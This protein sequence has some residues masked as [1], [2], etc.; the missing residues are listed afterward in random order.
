MTGDA[1]DGERA[2]GMRQASH[3]SCTSTR[4]AAQERGHGRNFAWLRSHLGAF[5]VVALCGVFFAMA[6]GPWREVAH[7]FF[8]R[9]NPFWVREDFTAFY[10]AGHIVGSGLGSHLYDPGT[11]RAAEYAAAGRQ[12]GGTGLLMYFNPPFFALLYWPLSHL[13]LQQAYQAW[14]LFSVGLLALNSWLLVRLTPGLSRRWHVVLITGYLT[15]YPV[16]FGLRLGQFSLILQASWAAGALL[17]E[18][19]RDRWAGL[20]LAP[21]LIKPELLIPAGLFILVKRHWGTFIT[22]VPMA[23]AAIVVSVAMVGLATAIHYPGFVLGSTA[24]N[25]NG[26]APNLMVDYSGAIAAAFGNGASVARPLVSTVLAVLSLGAVALL[27]G[28]R[29]A[30]GARASVSGWL[31]VRGV[32]RAFRVEWLAISLAAVLCD[33]HLYLQDTI[34]VVPAAVALLAALPVR[35]R[36]RFVIVLAIGWAIQRVALYPNQ[37]LHLDL[38]A[39]FLTAM[40][41]VLLVQTSRARLGRRSEAIRRRRQREHPRVER[42]GER[43]R[44]PRV[45]VELG[46]GAGGSG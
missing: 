39:L 9:S 7:D 4:T 43:Q 31:P 13:S 8:G 38:F 37:H 11:M 6:G 1:N 25:G 33:P 23:L 36:N 10:A 15:L 46:D 34:I 28:Q 35:A 17:L 41:V 45:A 40:L 32:E 14:M 18:Q 24:S 42:S 12:V 27:A 3:D 29:W 44:D 2:E 21:L 26:V 22:L 20:A 19:R 30:P 16:T 5:A